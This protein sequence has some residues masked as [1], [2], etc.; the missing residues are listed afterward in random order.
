MYL[1]DEEHLCDSDAFLNRVLVFIDLFL[2]RGDL[3]RQFFFLLSKINR[4]T[5]LDKIKS[6]GQIGILESSKLLKNL[7]E[8]KMESCNNR[9]NKCQNQK[10]YADDD[11][12]GFSPT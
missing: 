6:G 10:L 9:S 12:A 3:F 11:D 1:L 4:E 8:I 5:I 2:L 7:D